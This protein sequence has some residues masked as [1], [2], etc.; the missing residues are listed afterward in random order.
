M[1]RCKMM[2]M[3]SWSLIN[4]I[5][6]LMLF[7]THSLHHEN[8]VMIFTTIRTTLIMTML[9]IMSCFINVVIL[10]LITFNMFMTIITIMMVPMVLW[11]AI[12]FAQNI[13]I[14]ASRT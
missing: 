12:S 14:P 4:I 1:L 9:L 8:F 11:I 3:F 6:I 5:V 13:I 7:F 2:T 10:S